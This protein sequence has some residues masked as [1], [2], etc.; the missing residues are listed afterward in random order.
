[1][2]KMPKSR[3]KN[4]SS[5]NGTTA[6]AP[7][8]LLDSLRAQM[9]PSSAQNY[10][11]ESDTD[12][13]KVSASGWQCDTDD[14]SNNSLDTF[15]PTLRSITQ[16]YEQS[17]TNYFLGNE[18]KTFETSKNISMN[19]IDLIKLSSIVNDLITGKRDQMA[20]TDFL[21]ILK[22]YSVHSSRDDHLEE[23]IYHLIQSGVS[24]IR[25]NEKRFDPLKLQEC[26]H[27]RHILKTNSNQ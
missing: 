20:Y 9:R 22:I 13:F 24:F 10:D 5:K 16:E 19:D 8:P 26:Y 23:T 17:K 14:W 3:T 2:N 6:P 11:Y 12:N 1:M 27:Q 25:S 4:G 7:L 21:S 18:N 15:P